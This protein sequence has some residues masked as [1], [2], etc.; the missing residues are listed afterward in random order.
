[1]EALDEDCSQ[2]YAP[3]RRSGGKLSVD[4]DVWDLRSEFVLEEWN[5]FVHCDNRTILWTLHLVQ[6]SLCY[7]L[8]YVLWILNYHKWNLPF[9]QHRIS[10]LYFAMYSATSIIIFLYSN[11]VALH[12]FKG[13]LSISG[14]FP[15]L[16]SSFTK[17]LVSTGK[18]VGDIL[19]AALIWGS[20]H[21]SWYPGVSKGILLDT[22]L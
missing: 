14:E 10:P 5:R 21:Q 18:G 11:Y 3:Y 2:L 13:Q 22:D 6:G 19:T 16:L 12:F 4:S 15:P 20:G 17:H 8:I 1:M 9:I 7:L